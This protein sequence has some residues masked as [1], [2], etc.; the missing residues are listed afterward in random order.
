MSD[1]RA[2][3]RLEKGHEEMQK[4]I[5]EMATQ[6]AV[7]NNHISHIAETIDRVVLDHEK[8]I[9]GNEIQINTHKTYWKIAGFVLAPALTGLV[10]L[11]F[12][13]VTG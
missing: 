5:T 1:S 7:Q 13:V 2:I 8:R 10:A 6:Q 9:S 11:G 3:E 12:A 4:A